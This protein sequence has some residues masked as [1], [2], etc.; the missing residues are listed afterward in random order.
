[1]N[2]KERIPG[3]CKLVFA[4]FLA[5]LW[6]FT[7]RALEL[8][9][10]GNLLEMTNGDVRLEYN[11]STGQA[12]F[13]WRNSMIVSNF[14]AS[15]QL[16]PSYFGSS[17]YTS[18]TWT[19]SSNT[20]TVTSTSSSW[21]MMFQTFIFDQNDSFLTSMSMSASTNL[22][23][24]WMSPF[25]VDTSGFLNI[26]ITNDNRALFVPFDND[27]FVSYNSEAMNS[28]DTSYEAGAFYDNTSR[29]G[30]VIGSV[31]HDKW[32]TGIWWSGGNNEIEQMHAFGGVTGYWTWDVAPHGMVGGNVIT[33]PVIFVGFGNDWR[34]TMED[35]ADEN[36]LYAPM[37]P[38]TNGVPFGWNSWGVTN[39]QNHITYDA[40]ISVS[41]S[42]HTNLQ[43]YGFTNNGTVY[44]NL[45]SYWSNLGSQLQSFVN[46][47]HANG[48]KAG[49]YWNPFTYFGSL[50]QATNQGVPNSSYHYSDILL[51][52][53]NGSGISTDGAYAIDP[54]HPGTQAMI[55]YQINIF[56]ND[57]FDFI[58]LDFLSHA[59]REG[60]HYNSSIT[61]GIE[62]YNEGMQYLYN[63][64]AGTMFISES[65]APLFPYQYAHSRRIACDAE[66]SAITNTLYTMNSVS[67]GWWI[68]G[69]LYQYNDPDIMVFDNGR[70]ANEAQSRVINGAVTGLFLNG[71]ILTNAASVAEAQLCLTNAGI[72]AVARV[73][74]TFR[75]VDGAMGTG[76]GNVF[77]RQDGA[78]WCIAVFNYTGSASNE[79]VNLSSAGLPR[80]TFAATNLWDGTTVLATNTLNV[81]LLAD[82]AKLFRLVMNNPPQPRIVSMSPVDA[83]TFAFSGTNGIP[84]WNYCVVAT[85]NPALPVMQWQLVVTNSFDSN[86]DFSFTN[87]WGSNP[88]AFY[89][90][91][92]Q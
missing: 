53:T 58:K 67:L 71:S 81:S 32:K 31:T 30:L 14:Y 11:L 52:T 26:G 80:E 28:S 61:T 27:G 91:K 34:T 57:A 36:E 3:S 78:T 85:T 2:C 43:A 45:D 90:L 33:S 9:Q 50:A 21:P 92:L 89:L 62:A 24:N 60:V 84:G 83:S 41:D 70:T 47:C 13:R 59:S 22:Q 15:V 10:T 16:G 82:Q 6:A 38:W 68:S 44:V 86:G 49:V 18:H 1:M 64:I 87:N 51:R 72:N 55:R 25:V 35:F 42:I 63:Q 12:N 79:T 65:I 48:Q 23:S 77:V 7:G 37:L 5:G 39:Y 54:T 75:P 76:A 4:I 88:A 29:H 19:V 56:T 69:R 74:Q 46:H 17:I 66:N 40:A 73:G 20:V 8:G